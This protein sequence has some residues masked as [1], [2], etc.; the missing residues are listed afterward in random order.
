MQSAVCKHSKI[1][2]LSNWNLDI[3]IIRQYDITAYEFDRR[4]STDVFSEVL[5]W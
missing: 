4:L 2:Q 5:L 1:L 3:Q